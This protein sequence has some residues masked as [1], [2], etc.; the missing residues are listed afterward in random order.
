MKS[1]LILFIVVFAFSCKSNTSQSVPNA[2]TQDS[3]LLS[4]LNEPIGTGK[5]TTLVNG[6]DA[7][8][9]SLWSSSKNDQKRIET[10]SHGEEVYIIEDDFQYYYIEVVKS[11]TKGY[12]LKESISS[13]KWK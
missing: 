4:A 5:I 10:L 2:R 13:I 9:V 11:K 1:Y 3:L 6:K 8:P 7:G 12:C